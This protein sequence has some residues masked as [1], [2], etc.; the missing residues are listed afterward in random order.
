MGIYRVVVIGAES[1]GKTTIATQLAQHYRTAWAP[2]YL[3]TFVE[4]NGR[5]PVAQDVHAVAAGHLAQ[6]DRLLSASSAV[7]F[8][9]TDL[10]L[11]CIYQ[12]HYFGSCPSW[13]HRQ[14]VHHAADLYLVT[15]P[16]FPWVADPGQREGPDVQA[17][18]HARLLAEMC[19]EGFRYELLGG[20]VASRLAVSIGYVDALL[21]GK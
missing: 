12:Q 8:L 7:L 14:A 17:A 18:I 13:L 19:R 9:D 16:D 11:T 15:Q 4:E 10:V 6:Q 1:T 3:R 20:P 5:L 21:Q 2:E